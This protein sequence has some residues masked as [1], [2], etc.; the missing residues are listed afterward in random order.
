MW[1]ISTFPDL[2]VNHSVIQ[3]SDMI[4][5][6]KLIL[7]LVEVAILNSII[8]LFLKRFWRLHETLDKSLDK[9]LTNC[10]RT[11]DKGTQI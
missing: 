7:S 1:S 11:K 5:Y 4:S 3:L 2:P 8:L 10:Q 9:K 6:Q